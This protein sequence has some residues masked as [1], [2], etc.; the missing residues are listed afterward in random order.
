MTATT[1]FWLGV[2]ARRPLDETY[3][4]VTI[5]ARA[6][7]ARVRSMDALGPAVA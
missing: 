2:L 1:T 5:P 7:G 6:L 3:W 4:R